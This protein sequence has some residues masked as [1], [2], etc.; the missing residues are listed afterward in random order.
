[1]KKSKIFC[2]SSWTNDPHFCRVTF[3]YGRTRIIRDADVGIR[4]ICIKKSTI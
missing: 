4:L 2:G 3:R 1:M